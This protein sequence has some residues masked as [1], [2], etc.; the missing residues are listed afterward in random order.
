[1]TSDESTTTVLRRY[2]KPKLP[3]PA[4][5]TLG[6]LFAVG[7]FAAF[8]PLLHFLA[9]VPAVAAGAPFA[10]IAHRLAE[11]GKGKPRVF[12]IGPDGPEIHAGD[13]VRRLSWDDVESI[14][15][16]SEVEGARVLAALRPGGRL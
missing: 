11:P 15:I 6:A 8:L 4:I 3:T 2:P 1:M 14:T 16:A 9:I 5:W 13:D 12:R 10:T 7:M